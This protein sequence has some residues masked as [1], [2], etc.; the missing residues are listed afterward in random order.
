MATRPLHN[1]VDLDYM[2][3]GYM[4]KKMRPQIG[5]SR[6]DS[7]KVSP[8]TNLLLVLALATDLLVPFLIWK[9]ILPAPTR[10]VSHI[11]VV[12]LMGLAYA[13]MMVFD[14][15][16]GAAWII[17]GILA[18]GVTVALF[19]GQG[20]TATAWGCL[21]MFQYPLVGLYAYLQPHWP[22]RLPQRLCTFC[23]A[24]LGMEVIVQIGQYLTSQTPGDNLAGTFGWHGTGLLVMFILFVLCLALGQWLAS[25][26]WKTLIWVL[27]LGSVS[28]VLGEMKIFPVAALALTMLAAGFFVLK[29]GHLS[30]LVP[31]VV[32]LGVTVWIF[33]TGYNMFVPIAKRMPI[34]QFLLDAD[35]LNEYLGSISGSAINQ[36]TTYDISRNFAVKYGW[37]TITRD[38]TTFLFGFG[39]GA[40]GESKTLGTTG[41]AL[42][43]AS[44]K[45]SRRSS[46]LVLM[47]EMGLLGLIGM[48]G[49]VLW[50]A[51]VLFRDIRRYPQSQAVELRYALLLFSLLWP[52]WLWY[53]T[54][55]DFR[56]L[57]LLY[58]G[59]LG[60]VLGEPRR[61]HLGAQRSRLDSLS[62][63]YH[64]RS[65]R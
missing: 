12:T 56:V 15:I 33:I 7:S 40:R 38:T 5:S 49:F 63:Q 8:Q 3:L 58:W 23:T 6:L 35:A 29:G 2:N 46:L 57:M 18:I 9:G 43:Q 11:A 28:S 53:Q 44:L 17:A 48:G 16:P 31:Y 42:E 52:V 27:A 13:R 10:W 25:G 19:G 54:V 34:D 65:G 55:W 36:N 59:A 47:Q 51:V 45:M 37:S 30:K 14:Q 64:D 4:R 32:L 21:M 20:I 39:L 22:D 60:Y 61:H 41:I 50:V 24:I 1:S 26:Q 62:S